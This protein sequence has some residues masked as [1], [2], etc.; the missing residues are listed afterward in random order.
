MKM[1]QCALNLMSAL[2]LGCQREPIPSPGEEACISTCAS[3]ACLDPGLDSD[4]ITRCESYCLDKFAASDAQGV[5]CADA[6]ADGMMC[7]AELSCSEYNDWLAETTDGPCPSARGRVLESC[8]Q[9]FLEPHIL[10]P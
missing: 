5:D 3:V 1:A 4:A 7:L 9:I 8:Q 6:Y 10:P 2:L